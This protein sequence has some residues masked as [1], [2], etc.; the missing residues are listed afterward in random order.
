MK[1]ALRSILR[2][3]FLRGDTPTNLVHAVPADAL[4]HLRHS[5]CAYHGSLSWRLQEDDKDEERPC[6]QSVSET[7]RISSVSDCS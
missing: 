7:S 2:F 3:L 1:V 4:R 6:R 5:L